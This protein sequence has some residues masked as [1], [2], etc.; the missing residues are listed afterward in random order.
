LGWVI[1][2]VMRMYPTV[3]RTG[4]TT[5]DEIKLGSDMTVPKGTI[6]LIDIKGMHTNPNYWESPD[7]FKPERFENYDKKRK[8]HSPFG[9]AWKKNLCW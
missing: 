8:E 2:E 6:V 3:E 9:G 1:N 4:R 5:E 7:K